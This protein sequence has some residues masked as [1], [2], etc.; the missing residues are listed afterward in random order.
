M[1]IKV[2]SQDALEEAKPPQGIAVLGFVNRSEEAGA[3]E[4]MRAVLVHA[5]EAGGARVVDSSLVRSVDP[6]AIDRDLARRLCDEL[7]VEAVITGTV[8]AYGYLPSRSGPDGFLPTV[9]ADIRILTKTPT[10]SPW[11]VRVF[12]EDEP[13][14]PRSGAS[15]T[16]LSEAAMEEVL[17]ELGVR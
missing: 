11:V 5:L 10:D 8:F 12:A 14:F 1:R 7:K 3:A 4:A 13:D 6:E 17:E 15:L 16:A 9:R 2:E